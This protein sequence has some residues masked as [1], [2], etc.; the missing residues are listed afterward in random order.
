MTIFASKNIYQLIATSDEVLFSAIFSNIF[1][2]I[3]N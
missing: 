1:A 2:T 3:K